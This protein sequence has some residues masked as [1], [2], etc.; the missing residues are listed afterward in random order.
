MFNCP[1][2]RRITG[3]GSDSLY[4]R[5]ARARSSSGYFFSATTN[6]SVQRQDVERRRSDQRAVA[7]GLSRSGPLEGFSAEVTQVMFSAVRGD[8]QDH[9][10]CRTIQFGEASAAPPRC[11]GDCRGLL[12]GGARA[13]GRAVRVDVAAEQVA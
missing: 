8:S 1:A 2:N 5:T 13:A 10:E 12:R 3:F 4:N 7:G 6:D 11:L 9:D